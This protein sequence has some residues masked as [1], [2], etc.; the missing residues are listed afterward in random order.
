MA[1]SFFLG[2]QFSDLRISAT[3]RADCVSAAKTARENAGFSQAEECKRI[4]GSIL[5]L[6]ARHFPL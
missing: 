3:A 1:F 2:R 4:A 5:L 6:S